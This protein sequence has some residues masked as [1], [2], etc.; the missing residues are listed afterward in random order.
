MINNIFIV[1]GK[2]GNSSRTNLEMVAKFC[3]PENC[4]WVKP[5]INKCR[6]VFKQLIEMYPLSVFFKI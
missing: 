4:V 6:M 5:K 1:C 2:W 3:L